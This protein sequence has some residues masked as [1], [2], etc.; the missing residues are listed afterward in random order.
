MTKYIEILIGI[1][2]SGKSTYALSRIENE[3]KL[4]RVNRDDLRFMLKNLPMLPGKM[5]SVLT[6]IEYGN[7]E[8]LLAAGYNVIWDNTNLKMTFINEIIRRFTSSAEIRFKIFDIPVEEAIK[9]DNARAR[10]VGENIINIMYNNYQILMENNKFQTIP[11]QPHKFNQVKYDKSLTDCVVFDIDGTLAEKGDRGHFDWDKVDVDKLIVTISEHVDFHRS[12]N[13]KIILVTGRS[14]ESRTKT[15][16]W[17]QKHGIVYDALYMR[18]V[19]DYRKD[20]VLKSEIYHNH[21]KDLY[22][23][24]CVYEDR[25]SVLN[26]WYNLGIF[27]F[28]V[29]QG[30]FKF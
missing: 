16:S 24:L 17:L 7:V 8:S 2:G 28:N 15:V 22:N 29:N 25:L 19:N 13:R 5:E 1:P 30:N 12:L 27:T 21:I 26:M 6:E 18:P 14:E 9:R 10:K 3:S 11:I 20:T 4:A 23:V